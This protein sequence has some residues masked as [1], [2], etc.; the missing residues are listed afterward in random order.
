[1]FE[2]AAVIDIGS[3]SVRML[4]KLGQERRQM[5]VTTRLGQGVDG[6]MLQSEPVR[7][8]IAAI[9]QFVET[10]RQNGVEE[11]YAFATSAVRDA[12]NREKLT[13]PVKLLYG[14]EIDVLPGE[15][16]AELAYLGAAGGEFAGVMDIGGASTELVAGSGSVEK[17]VSLQTGAVR[18]REAFGVDRAAA[19]KHLRALFLP[20]RETFAAYES[21]PFFGIGGTITTLS[22]MEQG[23][24]KYDEKRVDRFALDYACVEKWADKLWDT[25]VEQRIFPGLSEPRRE[26]IAHGVTILQVFMECFARDRIIVS[27]G[28]NLSGYLTSLAAGKNRT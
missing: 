23:I 1:M 20:Q 3:N 15:K 16:E 14:I 9:G 25:P 28:D 4:L 17:A 5:L 19:Q 27:T 21:A 12:Q 11:I 22:A 18:L 10:A 24:E 7:R 8:T 2:R 6:R 13:E 26:I